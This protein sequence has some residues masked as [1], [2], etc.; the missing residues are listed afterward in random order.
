MS[1]SLL[2]GACIAGDFDQDGLPDAWECH[3][4]G[5]SP[6]RAN[7]ILVPVLRPDVTRADVQATL[8]RVIEFYGNLTNL[9]PDG[10]TGVTIT[11][12]WGNELPASDLLTDYPEVRV[13]G[14]PAEMIGK[15]HGMLIGADTGGG[16]QTIGA[17]WSG[18]SNN[19][20][21]IVH[22]LGHQLGLEHGPRG[23]PAASPFYASIMNYD[24]IYKFNGSWESM[25]FS[26]GKFASLSLNER[27]L[28][29]TL[30]FPASDLEFL[31][32]GPYYYDI[33][34]LS[35]FSSSIDFNRNGVFSERGI[36]ADINDGYAVQAAGRVDLEPTAGG[37]ALATLGDS[38]ITV[39]SGLP[40]VVNWLTYI[41]GGLSVENPGLLRY[42]VY[43]GASAYPSGVLVSGGVTGDPHAVSAFDR[44]FVTYPTATGYG[45]QA[46]ESGRTAG[47]LSLLAAWSDSGTPGTEPTLVVAE[48]G[49]RLYLFLWSKLTR[50]VSVRE[51]T[52][53]LTGGF[54]LGPVSPIPVRSLTP[55][56]GAWNSH[57]NRIVLVSAEAATRYQRRMQLSYLNSGDLGWYVESA[58]WVGE[59][60]FKTLTRPTVLFDGR[61]S[62]GATGQTIVYNL[63]EQ[64]NAA[65]TL[66]YVHRM[67]QTSAGPVWRSRMMLNEWTSTRSP[68][69]VTFYGD[70]IAW[71]FRVNETFTDVPNIVQI[72]TQASGMIDTG[73]TD[74]DDVTWISQHGLRESLGGISGSEAPTETLFP[75]SGEMLFRA[76]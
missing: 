10:S 63:S 21:T 17:D 47:T 69:S 54:A 15:G 24:Y 11:I 13:R 70:D 32:Q 20:P 58:Q 75:P 4:D 33:Q 34:A 61:P 44:L 35:P 53:S 73:I 68:P 18:V 36:R 23:S 52:P 39:S 2:L 26:S 50:D 51:I 19:W 29:E 40:G 43:Q 22:E 1:C 48:N 16:G 60:V 59:Y 5:F 42:Q 38:L 37:L 31:T 49:E 56:G 65:L 72:F 6:D 46:F 67:T 7:L 14:M 8:D 45:V 3:Q 74:F 25:Q 76:P 9:N 62:A 64:R 71:G 28:S 66:S 55:V 12:H 27:D 41:L 57:L 30:P